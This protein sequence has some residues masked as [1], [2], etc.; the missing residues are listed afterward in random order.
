[1]WICESYL[2]FAMLKLVLLKM[3]AGRYDAERL[4]ENWFFSWSSILFANRGMINDTTWFYMD[5]MDSLPLSQVI[6]SIKG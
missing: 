2:C 6:L 5:C 1:M 3:T 4:I